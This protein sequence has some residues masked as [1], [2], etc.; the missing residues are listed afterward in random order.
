MR[1]KVGARV[2]AVEDITLVLD[3]GRV[4]LRPGS[5]G[6]V[7]DLP[8]QGLRSGLVGIA[9]DGIEGRPWYSYEHDVTEQE[10]RDAV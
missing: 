3:R 2:A 4:T 6:T 8:T 1:V 9:W 7:V 5:L 10:P